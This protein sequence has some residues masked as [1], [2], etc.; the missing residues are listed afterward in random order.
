MNSISAKQTPKNAS[1][2]PEIDS[3]YNL[4]EFK[5]KFGKTL[6]DNLFAG[7]FETEIHKLSLSDQ[8][9][10]DLLFYCP[11]QFPK[12]TEVV[13]LVSKQNPKKK[14]S[15]AFFKNRNYTKNGEDPFQTARSGELQRLLP[16]HSS[17]D[18]KKKFLDRIK[19][20]I[21][22]D[23]KSVS[24][25]SLNTSSELQTVSDASD[26]DENK[27]LSQE[28]DISINGGRASPKRQTRFQ[29]VNDPEIVIIPSSTRRNL[30]I[31]ET[32]NN[33]NEQK[34]QTVES[35]IGDAENTEVTQQIFHS[36]LF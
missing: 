26:S 4:T 7:N 2:F 3:R 12:F 14:K 21:W 29:S 32:E 8:E 16:V 11:F 6:S 10:L 18:K 23:S 1:E 22:D 28:S 35:V 31:K 25:E 17:V 5:N 30:L 36:V 34:S 20:G 19:N 15:S 9:A 24:A 33:D 27:E 13:K